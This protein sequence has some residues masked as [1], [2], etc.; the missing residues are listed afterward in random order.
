MSSNQA[1]SG[2]ECTCCNHEKAE[3]M[4]RRLSSG[5]LSNRR[6]AELYN[7]TES[8]I[9]RHRKAHMGQA[10]TPPAGARDRRPQAGAGAMPDFISTTPQ[11]GGIDALLASA[12]AVLDDAKARGNARLELAALESIRKILETRDKIEDAGGSTNGYAGPGVV[13]VS[14]ARP[15][16]VA[17]NVD[18]FIARLP[19]MPRG[20]ARLILPDN[21]RDDPEFG[22][23]FDP[24]D[25]ETWPAGY[26]GPPDFEDK[27]AG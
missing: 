12:Q 15:G 4:N 5:E 24:N 7:V 26:A 23:D 21:H 10:S 18:D 14:H 20:H 16:Q 9:R 11:R 22:P 1:F 19:S 17:D 25:R 6:A 2:R 13:I 8:A 3:E 27:N